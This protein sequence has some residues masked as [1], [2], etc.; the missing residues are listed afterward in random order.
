[1]G[2]ILGLSLVAELACEGKEYLA[3]QGTIVSVLLGY[4]LK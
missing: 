1:L 4:H 2:G 3:F